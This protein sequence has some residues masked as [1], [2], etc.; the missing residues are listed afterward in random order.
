MLTSCQKDAP[1]P[2]P[3]AMA[4]QAEAASRP[5]PEVSFVDLE[6]NPRSLADY[7][8]AVTLVNFWA[9]WC[10]PCLAEMPEIE[11][12]EKSK[13]AEGLKLVM[14]NLEEPP[15]VIRNFLR[16]YGYTFPALLDTDG[17]VT[18]AFG[19]TGLPTSFFLDAKG[20]IRYE[21]RGRMTTETLEEGYRKA[22]EGR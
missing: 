9:S 19:V 13:R 16:E 20:I 3:P 21:R 4:A 18:R 17:A 6:G 10:V 22:R 15:S 14:I 12:F 7:R 8:G 1:P 2:P 5:A 11:R